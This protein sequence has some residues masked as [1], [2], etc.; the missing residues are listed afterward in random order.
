MAHHPALS[1]TLGSIA[2]LERPGGVRPPRLTEP[3]LVKWTRFR[4]K[5]GWSDFI[6]LLHQDLAEPFPVP[7]DLARWSDDPLH[8]LAES[9]AEALVREAATPTPDEPLV[10]LRSAARALGLPDGGAIAQLPRVQPHQRALELPGAAG[11]VAAHQVLTHGDLAFHDQFTFVA[12]TD[13]E[14]VL[15]GLAAVELRANP[16]T[17]LT[18]AQLADQLAGGASFDRVFGLRASPSAQALAARHGLEVR[19]A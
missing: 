6:A 16:P 18:S 8:G 13:A 1:W 14:R 9:D 12:D 10:Y 7:F 15:V 3:D 4:R 17:V 2:R 11:R 5:L 19:W